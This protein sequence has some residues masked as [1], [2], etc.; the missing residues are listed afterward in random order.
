M[1]RAIKPIQPTFVYAKLRRWESWPAWEQIHK[2]SVPRL[3]IGGVGW[4]VWGGVLLVGEV[5]VG[6]GR[7][8][9]KVRSRNKK[10]MLEQK[11]LKIR[12]QEKVEKRKELQM[13]WKLKNGCIEGVA[14]EKGKRNKMKIGSKNWE[15]NKC[16]RKLKERGSCKNIWRI[17]N[18]QLNIWKMEWKMF[19]RW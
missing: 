12:K 19:A 2:K 16:R 11:I 8:E 10:K 4:G 3:G 17:K 13:T 18:W 6:E 9:R 15:K 1:A 5:L 7:L 14:W